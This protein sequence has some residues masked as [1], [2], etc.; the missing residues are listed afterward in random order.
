MTETQNPSVKTNLHSHYSL[1]FTHTIRTNVYL[2]FI[3]I[4]KVDPSSLKVIFKKGSCGVENH[5]LIRSDT[6]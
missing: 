4:L 3:F 2:M 6:T 1:L 5:I